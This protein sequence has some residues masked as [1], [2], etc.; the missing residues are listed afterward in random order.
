MKNEVNEMV[1][2]LTA[3]EIETIK[4]FYS[5]WEQKK[6]E[7]LDEVCM[8]NWKDIPLAPGQEDNPN[9]L[10]EVM[11]QLFE[12]LP[13]IKIVVHEIF[14]THERAG[15]RA[16]FEFTHSNDILGIPASNKKVSLAVHEFHYLKD[17][18]L[19]HTWHLEDWFSLLMQS[20]SLNPT[21]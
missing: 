18:K 20:N 16:S 21:V 12:L 19:S 17:G 15:V 1:K 10:K 9:G 7:L 3:K 4:M 13:D 2:G 11:K 6:P 14:G 8:P 5:A